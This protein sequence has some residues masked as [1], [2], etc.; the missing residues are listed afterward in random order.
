MGIIWGLHGGCIGGT[1]GGNRGVT[2]E[3]VHLHT[4]SKQSYLDEKGTQCQAREEDAAS[5]YR[6]AGTV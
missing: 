5:V 6:Y 2:G 4:M 1:W 3:R